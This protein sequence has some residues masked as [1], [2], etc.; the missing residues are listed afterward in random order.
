MAREPS[1]GNE[2]PRKQLVLNSHVV[3]NLP[4]QDKGKELGEGS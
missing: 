3:I 2:A 1:L 4:K